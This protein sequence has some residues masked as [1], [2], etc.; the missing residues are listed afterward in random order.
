MSGYKNI[1]SSGT[2]YLAIAGI[3]LFANIEAQ[4]NDST[5]LILASNTPKVLCPTVVINSV[6]IQKTPQTIQTTPSSSCL[7]NQQNGQIVIVLGNGGG[8]MS[9]PCP[10]TFPYLTQ[11]SQTWGFGGFST[12]V[13]GGA[14]TQYTCCAAPNLTVSL[15]TDWVAADPTTGKCPNT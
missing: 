8:T 2:F 1:I 12:V 9:T 6:T 14:T 5:Q 11:I 7:T 4:A 13:G 15:T 10:S 3:V